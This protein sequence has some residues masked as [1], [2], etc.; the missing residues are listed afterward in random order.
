VRDAEGRLFEATGIPPEEALALFPPGR[1]R[2]V[3]AEA[4]RGVAA[5]LARA[6]RGQ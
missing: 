4:I 1:E 2:T 3:F 5:R 6:P